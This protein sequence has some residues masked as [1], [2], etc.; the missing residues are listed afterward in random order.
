[1]LEELERDVNYRLKR[2]TMSTRALLDRLHLLD[3]ASRKTSQYQD[4]N[5]LPF[6]YYLARSSSPKTVFQV[7]L[8]I[9][10][11]TCCFLSG[12]PAV[13]RVVAF[14]KREG[15]FYSPRMAISNIKIVRAS[16]L[17]F[18]FYLGSFSDESLE[19]LISPGVDMTLVT[20]ECSDDELNDI[21]YSSWERTNLGGMIVADHMRSKPKSFDVF[22]SFCKTQ[23]RDHI[24][25]ETRYGNALVRK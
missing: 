14:Q 23:N 10:L 24:F 2:Q 6:Y 21:L 5:Y 3:E 8:D 17:S 12:C 22:R 4:P 7:G 11:P 19:S 16:G 18:D 13:D 9:G 20:C 25:F 15:S 1:M